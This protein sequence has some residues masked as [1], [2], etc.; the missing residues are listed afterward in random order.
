VGTFVRNELFHEWFEYAPREFDAPQ[1]AHFAGAR[2]TRASR[3]GDGIV[4]CAL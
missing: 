3:H 4:Q 2:I 1:D